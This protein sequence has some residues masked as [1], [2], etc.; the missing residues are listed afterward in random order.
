MHYR[1][2]NCRI[3]SFVVGDTE[4]LCYCALS[5]NVY[6][7]SNFMRRVPKN[8]ILSKEREEAARV[9]EAWEKQL[10]AERRI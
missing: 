2:I 8:S 10:Q 1:V 7:L 6:T 9:R 5:N 4:V 3:Y